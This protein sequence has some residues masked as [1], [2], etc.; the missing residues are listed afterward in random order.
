MNQNLLFI[1]KAIGDLKVSINGEGCVGFSV[2]DVWTNFITFELMGDQGNLFSI[3]EGSQKT[4]AL[5]NLRILLSIMKV[6][7][8][9]NDQTNSQFITDNVLTWLKTK[10]FVTIKEGFA[11]HPDVFKVVS[12][13]KEHGRPVITL[14]VE[15]MMNKHVD[16]MIGLIG[17]ADFVTELTHAQVFEDRSH[18]HRP[19]GKTF[20]VSGPVLYK[21][22]GVD[23][24]ELA[25]YYYCLNINPNDT[26]FPT[27]ILTTNK[28]DFI[29]PRSSRVL[30][31]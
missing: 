31:V 10:A 27:H 8:H 16:A 6:V 3:A 15:I 29:R 23:Q 28:F 11:E 9:G 17:R 13:F 5:E 30:T 21:Q 1:A 14:T 25:R 22:F 24:P 12:Q 26:S 2:N 20:F 19:D 18:L 4:F 7:P